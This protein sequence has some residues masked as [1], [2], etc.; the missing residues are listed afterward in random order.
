MPSVTPFVQDRH[1]SERQPPPS[2][3]DLPDNVVEPW[4]CPVCNGPAHR[5]RR[6]GRPKLYCSNACRQR[7][8]RWRRDH[9]ARTIARPGHPAA[10]ALVPFGRWHALRTGRDFVADLSDRRH[11]QPTVCGAFARPAR[12][13]PH[14]TD[15]QF[16][17]ASRDACRTCTELIA[18]PLD[19]LAPPT[20]EFT[21]SPG[22][23]TERIIELDEWMQRL[24]P[25]HPIRRHPERYGQMTKPW[26]RPPSVTS[27]RTNDPPR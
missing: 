17:T 9:Q 1:M 19:P 18:P 16:V 25:T 12:L 4:W 23:R 27:H 20:I 2:V 5:T 21:P 10:G 13:L 24:D 8:Y 6:P 7:A 3:A 11:R 26:W 22:R 14:R 15:H